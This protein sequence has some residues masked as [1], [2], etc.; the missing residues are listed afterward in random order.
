[1]TASKML[2]TI[3]Q[4][5]QRQKCSNAKKKKKPPNQPTWIKSK[6]FRGTAEVYLEN[7]RTTHTF[8]GKIF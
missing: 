7:Y 2:V 5:F 1:M 8:G 4:M 3:S 6:L